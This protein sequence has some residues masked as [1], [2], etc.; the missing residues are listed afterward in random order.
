M[1][2]IFIFNNASRAA[3]YGIGTYIKQLTGGLS[4]IPD[5]KVSLVEMYADSKEFAIYDDEDGTR[6]YLIPPLQSNTESETYCRIIFYFLARN[7]NDVGNN[8]IVFQF[9]YFQHYPLAV[10]LKSWFINSYIVQTVHYMGWCFELNGNVQRMKTITA[11]GYEP[12]NDKE[13][14]V[15]AS[16]VVE[17]EF[18]H[19]ADVVLVLSSRTM[20]ILASDYGVSIGKMHLVYNGIADN[21]YCNSFSSNKRL[22]RNI[23][24]VGRLDEIKGLK[25]LINAYGKIVN[26]YPDTCLVIVGDGDFQ[27]YLELCRK[28]SGHVSFL[29]KMQNDD[30]DKV[31]NSAYI[32]VM[33]SF[34]EQCSYTAIEMMRHGI[35]IIGT[36]STG[37]AEML[38]AT[39]ELR[40]HID[41]DDFNEDGFI[42]QIVSKMDLLLSDVTAYHLASD[43]VFKQYQERYTLEAMTRGVQDAVRALQ[44][45]PLSIVSPDYLPH[46]DNQMVALINRHPDID[47]DFFGMAG[48]GIYLWW[49]VLQLEKNVVA[50][51][52]QLA[53][54]KEHLIY[55]IDW[56]EEIIDD[57]PVGDELCVMFT[58][59]KKHDFC[60]TLVGHILEHSR[61]TCGDMSFPSEQE[62]IHNA[63]KIC[64]CKI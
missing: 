6:H 25:Y 27:P 1:T 43:A 59:M 8:K 20:D 21:V 30:V 11:E 42:S 33:P 10:L 55:Y 32:G 13:R 24:Y 31:Y 46:M 64:T 40:V 2:N 4:A 61:V 7:I 63:L 9:N 15:I 28:L 38:D 50:N 52:N 29:G 41:E 22:R 54:I 5:T 39:P 34:H 62:I 3:S 17:K 56:V 36:D 58:D 19:L 35:P 12:N 47:T 45:N 60:P 57:E 16:Y 49:R 48:I 53:M 14:S 44:I 26:K 37:L 23:L 18:L 51:A